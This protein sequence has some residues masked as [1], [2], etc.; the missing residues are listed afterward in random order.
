MSN[1]DVR[2]RLLNALHETVGH[3]GVR[4]SVLVLGEGI[5]IQ[6]SRPRGRDAE[7]GWSHIL[8]AL[9]VS[10]HGDPGDFDRL[11]SSAMQWTCLVELYARAQ[12]IHL[13]SA[14]KSLRATVSKRLKQVEAKRLESRTLYADILNAGFA[15]IVWFNIDRRIIRHVPPARFAKV[16][17]ARSCLY[18]RVRL[19]TKGDD[20]Y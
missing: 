12:R 15:N 8:R 17:A 14:E 13:R 5:N 3:A 18:R 1:D 4:T 19:S 11:R 6:A 9:W 20:S 16:P 2:K 10:A 7:D